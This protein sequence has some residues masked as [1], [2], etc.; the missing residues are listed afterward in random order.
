M[1]WRVCAVTLF[2]ACLGVDAQEAPTT[3]TA[4]EVML[5]RAKA[6]LNDLQFKRADS[7]AR[8]V[9]SVGNRVRRGTRVAALQVVAAAN[10]PE[11]PGERNLPEAKSALSEL[12]KLDLGGVIPRDLSWHGLDSLFQDVAANIFAMSV[13]AR[14][15]NP[16]NGIEGTSL[17]R[18]RA[19]RPAMLRLVAR[20]RD[21]I[22]VITLDSV[23]LATDTTLALRVARNGRTILRGGEYEF[24][25]SATSPTS[26]ETITRR[27]DGITIVP[28]IQ[29]VNLPATIDTSR[30]LPERSAT[31]RAGAVIGGIVAGAATVALG[32]ALRQKDPIRAAGEVD[33]RYRL[34]AGMIVI[35]S[36][37]AGWFDRGRKLDK[38]RATNDRRRQEY[39]GTLR[40]A[41]LENE[42]RAT[43][44]RANIALDVEGR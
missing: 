6:A 2:A 5:E 33:T 35:G 29:Y 13:T 16:I 40:T 26:R 4:A 15:E 43:D 32:Q 19:N 27:I 37:A 42:R 24:V 18:V 20:S 9:L 1:N 11:V 3:Q 30:L 23:P 31:Q 28:A 22:D 17:M 41:R 34:V 14:R 10:Y 12:I 44:Y 39:E 36:G 7:L 21:G 8:D 38:N 25:V